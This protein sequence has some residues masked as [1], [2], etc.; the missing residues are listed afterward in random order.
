MPHVEQ[1]RALIDAHKNSGFVLFDEVEKLLPSRHCGGSELE[2]TLLAIEAAG[3][4]ILDE[5][6]ANFEAAVAIDPDPRG[7]LENPI[8]IYLREIARFPP[9]TRVR[10]FELTEIMRSG[11]AQ[12]A[13]GALEELV[14]SNILVVVAIAKRYGR[15][16]KILDLVVAGNN[17]LV[18]AMRNFDCR[19]GYRFSSYAIWWIRQSIIRASRIH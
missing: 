9:I 1:L 15:G 4:E 8:K 6:K 13:A 2:E 3:L 11:D 16:V 19:R 12:A 14:Q 17:G 7:D 18:E 10:E 5:P